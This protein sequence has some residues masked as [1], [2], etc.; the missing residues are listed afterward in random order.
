MKSS[1][2]AAALG[3]LMLM[4]PSARAGFSDE[5]WGARP[6]GLGKAYIGVADDAYGPFRNARSEAPPV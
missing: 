4:A 3:S 6:A 2:L 1:I 5:A